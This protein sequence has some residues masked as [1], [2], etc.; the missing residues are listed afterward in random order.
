M[1]KIL[2][3][4]SEMVY[5]VLFIICMIAA[6]FMLGV[7]R[8]SGGKK[9]GT[10]PKKSKKTP[11][12]NFILVLFLVLTACSLFFFSVFLYYYAPFNGE[13]LVARAVFQKSGGNDDFRLVLTPYEND[14]PLEVRAFIVK[15]ITWS[16]QGEVLQWKPI[17]G[18]AG[19][20]AM[21]R[22]TEINGHYGTSASGK[23]GSS[24]R[25]AGGSGP[26]VWKLVQGINGVIKLARVAQHRSEKVP[27]VWS[28]GYDVFADA[29]GF[30]VERSRGSSPLK[31]KEEEGVESKER[32]YPRRPEDVRH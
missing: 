19:L 9:K 5:V 15:G 29:S 7:N 30:R 32:P 25:L 23:K 16:L 24:A 18:K 28:G 17:L 8:M 31:N 6:Y 21:Y 12:L 11:S 10:T 3:A 13:A 2:P 27:P 14:Q 1:G 4:N 22:L 20:H 26:G